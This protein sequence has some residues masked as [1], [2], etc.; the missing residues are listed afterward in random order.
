[1]IKVLL[2]YQPYPRLYY[3]YLENPLKIKC[4]LLQG[5][6]KSRVKLLTGE[7]ADIYNSQIIDIKPVQD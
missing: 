6:N 3:K 2:I 5:E 7:E 4:Y 1:M